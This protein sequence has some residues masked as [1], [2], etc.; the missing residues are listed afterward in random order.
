MTDW[1]ETLSSD[2]L[3][4]SL[5]P[6]RG[7]TAGMTA[8]AV[9]A[10]RTLIVDFARTKESVTS[11]I[12]TSPTRPGT[13]GLQ[14]MRTRWHIRLSPPDK[15]ELD[16][17][18]K[19]AALLW[20]G[21]G[22]DV[23]AISLAGINS[24]RERIAATKPEYGEKSVVD[25]VLSLGRGSAG[26]VFSAMEAKPCPMASIGCRFLDGAECAIT[27]DA[28]ASILGGLSERKILRRRNEYEPY[29]FSVRI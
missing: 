25:T 22:G 23:K 12:E 13:V 28:V 6:P 15:E 2:S 11:E 8:D 19:W 24:M 18:I 20:V 4:A 5:W 17:L 16:T 21:S 27:F 29:E 9:H 3:P 14:F 10:L 26:E 7:L 1:V